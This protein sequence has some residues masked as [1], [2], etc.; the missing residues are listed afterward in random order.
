MVG[1]GVEEKKT[2]KFQIGRL[3]GSNASSLEVQSI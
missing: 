2:R 1:G 3:A